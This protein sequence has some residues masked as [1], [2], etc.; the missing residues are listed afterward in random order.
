MRRA[1]PLVLAALTVTC[2]AEQRPD[3][4]LPS[5]NDGAARRAIV[6]FVGRV[7]REGGPDFVPVAERIATFDNDGTLWAEKP[8]PFQLFFTFDRVK[9]LAAQHPEWQTEEPFASVLKGD[10]AAVATSGE[11]GIVQLLLATHTGMT[12]EEFSRAVDEWIATARHPQTKRLYT[13]MV[14]QPMLELLAYLRR[15]SRP[16]SCRAGASS[17][18][19]PGRSASTA[20]RRSRLSAAA[21]S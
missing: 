9:A 2:A 8:V 19:V 17:S 10:L 11:K 21:A 6:D 13:E 7:T 14:Y 20:F 1:L 3:D 12:T 16:T 15:P 5:W 18:C 4:S